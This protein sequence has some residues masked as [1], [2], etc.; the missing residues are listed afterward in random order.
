MES[1]TQKASQACGPCRKHKRK[2]D[3]LRPE[4]SLCVRTCRTCDYT[5]TPRPPP[6]AAEFATLQERLGKLENRLRSASEN[7]EF[8]LAT[9]SVESASSFATES[10]ATTGPSQR[11]SGFPSA[12]FL[13]LD[14]YKWSGMQLPRPAVGIP[15][16]VL[17]ILGQQNT[18]L[19]TSTLYFSTIHCWMPIISKKRLELGISLQNSGPDLAL[20]F[21]TMRLNIS[22]LPTENIGGNSLYSTAK[23]F[24][25][26]L[27]AGG[28]VTLVYL[29]AMVLVATYEYSHSIYPAAWMT[30]G[31]CA[32]L[33]EL[34]G[35]SSGTDSMKIMSRV[36]TW[37]EVEER[38]RVWW[39]IF[40]LDRVISLGS[41]RRFSF[42]EPADVHV[43]PAND[44]A[45]D[46]G[47]I[48]N[49]IQ[50]PCTAPLSTYVSPFARLCQSAM[51]ISRVAVC[52]SVSQAASMHHIS[53]VTSLTTELCSFRSIIADEIASSSMEEYLRLLAPCCLTWSALFMLLDSYCCPEKL[54]DEPGYTPSGDAKGPEELAIQIQA[55]L[56]VRSIS[57][58]A[59]EHTKRLMD[60]ISHM[61]GMDP[62]GS[63]SPFSLDALYCSMVTFQWVYREGG[64]ELTEARLA[65]IEFCM[66]RLGERWRLASEYL[67]LNDLYRNAGNI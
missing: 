10:S 35:L 16:E 42:P 17:G 27:E 44:E 32:R 56:V 21:L 61:P 63:V 55:T 29:Q 2:C 5:D 15:M 47:N 59:Y 1:P 51:F 67:S 37:T 23:S 28:V 54:G 33:A 31:A 26:T 20:L 34:L 52:S 36:T 22:T 6:T 3:K 39:A 53:A 46:S 60:V 41:R 65:D 50:Y 14:C 19:E 8:A 62:I 66:R 40:I 7:P 11:S 58:E 43:L 49:I 45:W 18:V 38:R 9:A 4:C 12:L 48:T 30:V 64:D 13:D 24:L 25:A 57:D